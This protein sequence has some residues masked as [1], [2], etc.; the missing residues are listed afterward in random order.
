MV[1][2]FAGESGLDREEGRLRIEIP[3]QR[4]TGN[5]HHN[6]SDP[7]DQFRKTAARVEVQISNGH[8]IDSYFSRGGVNE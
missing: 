3:E 7:L 8:L 1:V 4:T 2:Q 5:S 6:F